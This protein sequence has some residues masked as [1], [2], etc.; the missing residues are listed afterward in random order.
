MTKREQFEAAIRGE[1][2]G[3]CANCLIAAFPWRRLPSRR[4]CDLCDFFKSSFERGGI[5]AHMDEGA[6]AGEVFGLLT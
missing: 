2:I 6:V 3:P 4:S 5:L 1:E